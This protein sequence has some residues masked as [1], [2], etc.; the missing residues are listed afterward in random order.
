LQ[1]QLTE[2]RPKVKQ[3]E[4]YETRIKQLTEM[5]LLWWVARVIGEGEGRRQR[6]GL[7]GR[8]DDV[9]RVK[10]AEAALAEM[11]GRMYQLEQVLRAVEKE[12]AEQTEMIR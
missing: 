2:V 3:I 10:D 11:R 8:D 6:A 9:Q 1:N 4:D 5:Q 7:I 12:K